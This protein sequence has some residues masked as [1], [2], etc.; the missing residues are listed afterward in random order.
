MPDL[1][2]DL[3]DEVQVDFA[4]DLEPDSGVKVGL[5]AHGDGHGEG[6]TDYISST[7]AGASTRDYGE[8]MDDQIDADFELLMDDFD[9]LEAN[10][11]NKV[12]FDPETDSKERDGD[13]NGEGAED[14]V[15][16]IV[17]DTSSRDYGVDVDDQPDLVARAEEAQ[18]GSEVGRSESRQLRGKERRKR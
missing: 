3:D 9:R 2:G 1:G 6:A 15:D 18:I 8:D 11:Q 12:G 13:A 16:S 4:P 5:R 10:V 14:Y 17:A 7:V